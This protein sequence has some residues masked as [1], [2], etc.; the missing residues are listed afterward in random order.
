M[1]AAALLLLL[2]FPLSAQTPSPLTFTSTEVTAPVVPGGS[3][4]WFNMHADDRRSVAQIDFRTDSD[5]DGFVQWQRNPGTI[6][7]FRSIWTAVDMTSGRLMAGRPPGV[8]P[9]QSPFPPKAFLRDADGNFSNLVI[10]LSKMSLEWEYLYLLWVRPGTGAWYVEAADA[11]PPTDRDR[12]FNDLLVL[13]ASQFEPVD[14]VATPAGFVA[15]DLLLAIDVGAQ[16]WFGDT[17]DAHL[18]ESGGPGVLS[19]YAYHSFGE[20]GTRPVE[21][22]VLRRE[23]SDGTVSLRYATEN[24]TALA[25]VHYEAVAGTLTFGPGEIVKTIAVP[26]INDGTYSGDTSFKVNLT[27]PAGAPISGPA[28]FTFTLVDDDPKPQLS[29]VGG[30]TVQEGGPGTY[31]L[32]MQVRLTGATRLPVTATW[33]V[34]PDPGAPNGGT[35]VFEPGETE[36]SI[37]FRYAG[38]T[39]PGA[40]R[41]YTVSLDAVQNAMSAA[42]AQIKV[43]DD[44][45]AT[46]SVNDVSVN[47]NSSSVSV[48][49]QLS[50]P[51]HPVTLKFTT[52]DGTATAGVDYEARSG[53]LTFNASSSVQLISI[54]ILRDLLLSEPDETFDVV[55]SEVTNATVVRARATVTIVN[56]EPPPPGVVLDNWAGLE[57]SDA[58]F[59]LRIG[60]PYFR[61][62]TVVATT[63]ATGTTAKPD[64]DFVPKS[65]TLTIPAGQTSTTFVVDLVDDAVAEEREVFAVDLTNLTN[66]TYGWEK[67]A[68][69]SIYDDDG[70][71]LTVDDAT[72]VEGDSGTSTMRVR[73]HLNMTAAAP[74]RAGYLAQNGTAL[75]DRDFLRSGS[76]LTFNPGEREKFI[77]V[78][79]LGDRSL[80]PD[81]TFTVV[82]SSPEGASIA[83][84]TATC[85]IVNDDEASPSKRR[86]AR[87]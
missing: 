5:A 26:K 66:A 68:V 10:D 50:A 41:T 27:D 54:P 8:I 45:Y 83:R 21:I 59:V 60:T 77:E 44:D 86:S 73:I 62:I 17:V 3:A 24:G 7:T 48:A 49:V 79:I 81:E 36:K 67:F 43:I 74:V 76:T 20:A 35:L 4:V 9:A 55:V 75:I 2:A 11:D 19:A 40:D 12:S 65:Q 39:L 64:S 53:T 82:L 16:S 23:G 29:I 52:V 63:R 46:L 32:P 42:A 22:H 47:E 87:H 34:S 80:E 1:K 57:S 37:T 38:N 18:A 31:E 51:G 30:T 25:G 15:G 56:A 78:A 84:G 61:D 6:P 33:T 70:P 71:M 14:T 69:G 85:T 13:Q 58:T 28:S 72:L